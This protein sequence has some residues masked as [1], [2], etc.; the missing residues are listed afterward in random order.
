[1]TPNDPNFLKSKFFVAEPQWHL[2][3]GASDEDKK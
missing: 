2:K 3:D 1:M